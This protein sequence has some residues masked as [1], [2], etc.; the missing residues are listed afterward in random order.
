MALTRKQVKLYCRCNARQ[1]FMYYAE[2]NRYDFLDDPACSVCDKFPWYLVP[3]QEPG[4]ELETLR[5]MNRC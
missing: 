3:N 1:D 4:R 5:E 2:N